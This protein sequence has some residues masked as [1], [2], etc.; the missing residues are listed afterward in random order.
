MVVALKPL[1]DKFRVRRVQVSTYQSVSGAGKDGMDELWTQSR[2]M[3]VHDAVTPQE[4]TKPIA[5]NCI[6][7]HR[8]L[9]G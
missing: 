2:A 7:T 4:F 5:F 8:P 1:H 3:F 6:P 9:H